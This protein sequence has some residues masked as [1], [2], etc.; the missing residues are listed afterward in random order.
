MAE[1]IWRAMRRQHDHPRCAQ[2]ALGLGVRMSDLPDICVDEEGFVQPGGGGLLVSRSSDWVPASRLAASAVGTKNDPLVI[3]CEI[4]SLDVD[5]LPPEIVYAFISEGM[6]VLQPATRTRAHDF[7]VALC[8]T[9]GL[10]TESGQ[11]LCVAHEGPRRT[12]E[13]SLVGRRPISSLHQWVAERVSQ[14]GWTAAFDELMGI[15]AAVVLA[16]SE[17]EEDTVAAV[18]DMME[19]W[20]LPAWSLATD[21]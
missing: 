11:R 16:G 9:R 6:G 17:D 18:M 14:A 1:R 5:E 21:V 2:S 19:G 4:W 8:S 12:G 20:C 13:V 7:Q 3:N 15:R 10:W